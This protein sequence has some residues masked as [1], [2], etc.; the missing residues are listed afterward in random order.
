VPLPVATYSHFNRTVRAIEAYAE[1][2]PRQNADGTFV[3]DV[4]SALR[5]RVA[6]E[7]QLLRAKL[8]EAQTHAGRTDGDQVTPRKRR[9]GA[10]FAGSGDFGTTNH[11][12]QRIRASLESLVQIQA[13]VSL[14]R[15]LGSLADSLLTP[16]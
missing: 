16:N 5:L 10:A 14:L 9:S 7:D 4:D 2:L 1:S 12:A 11:D 3:S 6:T 15:A 13:A 8:A